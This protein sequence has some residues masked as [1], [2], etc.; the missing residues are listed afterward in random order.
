M[1][2]ESGKALIQCE[3][4]LSREQQEQEGAYA[5]SVR[6]VTILTPRAGAESGL[7]AKAVAQQMTSALSINCRCVIA[8]TECDSGEDSLL[9]SGSQSCL[10]HFLFLLPL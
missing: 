5:C 9:V 4:S 10:L 1:F 3:A 7:R 8:E 2:E 6:C